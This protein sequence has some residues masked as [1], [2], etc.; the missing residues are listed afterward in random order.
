MR[1]DHLDRLDQRG[2]DFRRAI[3]RGGIPSQLSFT[4][5]PA[6]NMICL[7]PSE[8]LPTSLARRLPILTFPEL[9]TL[10]AA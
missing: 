5:H 3:R 9:R 2:A 6:V 4:E 7:W 10:T 8:R 1:V